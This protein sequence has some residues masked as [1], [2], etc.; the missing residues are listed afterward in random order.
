MGTIQTYCFRWRTC[1]RVLRTRPLWVLYRPIASGGEHAVSGQTRTGGGED[2]QSP[3]VA[4][5]VCLQGPDCGREAEDQ[6]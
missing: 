6:Q 1:S 4:S 5:P 3:Q 2:W